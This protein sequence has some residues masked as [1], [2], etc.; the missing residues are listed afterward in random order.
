MRGFLLF[1]MWVRTGG[2]RRR[3]TLTSRAPTTRLRASRSFGELHVLPA[4]P[5]RNCAAHGVV[6]SEASEGFPTIRIPEYAI[7]PFCPYLLSRR[8]K[9]ATRRAGYQHE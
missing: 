7:N 5:Q 3:F 6:P 2:P 8:R 9:L 4:R 1:F